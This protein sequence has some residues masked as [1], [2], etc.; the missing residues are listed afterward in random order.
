MSTDEAFPP[1]ARNPSRTYT[2]IGLGA[3]GGYYGGRLAAAGHTVR[4]LV[5]SGAADI[6]RAGLEVTSPHGDIFLPTIDV[7]DDPTHVPPSDVVVLTTKTTDTLAALPLLDTLVGPSTQAVLVLQN[8]LGVEATVAERAGEVPVVGGMCFICSHKE[9]P[10][11][12]NHLDY[13][14]VTLGRFR[15]GYEPAGP[16]PEVTG[17]ADDLAAA[18]LPVTR[19]DALG[20]GR[21]KK[22]VWNIP[23]NG[24]SVVLDAGTD[25]LMAHS[26]TR[27]LVTSLMHEVH[28]AATAA[29]HC[30]DLSFVD[31]M[32]TDTEK[33]TPYAPSMKLD[34]DAGRP[35][36]LDAIYAAPIAAARAAG[37]PMR[38]VEALHHQLR[39]LTGP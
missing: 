34:F 25:Q 1:V 14:A 32:L 19:L 28:G 16:T 21:W 35:L 37:A 36:E 31:T 6:R 30:F 5:R 24:L 11:R 38:Q 4:F 8:G 3:I 26:A 22:L 9:G 33:M 15:P 23:Y 29:G 18:G 17:I 10:G 39:F 13:G 7:F 20:T 2:V 27:E 12:I